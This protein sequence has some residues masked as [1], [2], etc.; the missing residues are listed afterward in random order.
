MGLSLEVMWC[1]GILLSDYSYLICCILQ[2]FLIILSHAAMLMTLLGDQ[3]FRYINV[4]Q[5]LCTPETDTMY[6]SYIFS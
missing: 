6:V 1:L 4:E 3:F 2:E 5:L